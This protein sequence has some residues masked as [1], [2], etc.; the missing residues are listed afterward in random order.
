MAELITDMLK[1]INTDITVAF[2]HKDNK[3]FR[4]LMEAAFIESKKWL[5]PEGTP[6]FKQ[7]NGSSIQLG[8][9]WMI[10]N[11]CYVYTRTDLKP[12]KRESL[13]IQDLEILSKEDAIILVAIKDQKLTE[14][15]P[16]ITYDALRAVGYFQ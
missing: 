12:A 16:N 7:M 6:P 5:L 9:I 3:Y 10:G 11:K 15:Y 2:K 8:G 14:M 4:N 13:F 1:D